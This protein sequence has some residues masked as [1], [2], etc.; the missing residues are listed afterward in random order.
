MGSTKRIKYCFILCLM[1]TFSSCAQEDVVIE[2]ANDF[3]AYLADEMD[4]QGIPALSIHIFNDQE[5]LFEQYL[6]FTNLDQ[7]IPLAQ[8]HLF[9]LASVSKVVTGVALL[10]LY[11]QGLF[12][13]DDPINDYLP[14]TVK[15][16]YSAADITF[17]MLLTHTS[18]I[19]DGA[20]LDD[21]YYY[22]EDSPIE[23]ADFLE[24]YLTPGGSYYDETDN[25]H[26]FIPGADFEYSNIGSALIGVLVESI[27]GQPFDAYCRANIFEPMGMDNSFWRL[28]EAFGANR[29]IVQPYEYTGRD[30]EAIPHYTFTDYPNGGLRAN[31]SDLIKLVSALMQGGAFNN[32]R[33]LEQ[34]TVQMMMGQ[35][36][37][38][39]DDEVGLHLFK[40]NRNP[41]LWGHDGGEE[42]VS[43]IVGY[44]PENR[45]G[46]VILTNSG[47]ADLDEML[48]EAYKLGETL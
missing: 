45:I 43:T 30:F 3:E 48:I 4:I 11:D 13:L 40:M 37:E 25:F 47:E 28:E 21:Q 8:D 38:T 1:L 42:G 32:S 31:G 20:A 5:V 26:D 22:N 33:L 41:V 35:G 18:G 14:F 27:S 23:L 12:D 39:I 24:N 16:P 6:G 17:K 7:N 2:N 29:T 10:Q 36:I 9:L 15:S 46:V 44:S 19:A 34:Q